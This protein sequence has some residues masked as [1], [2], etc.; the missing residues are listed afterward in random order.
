MVSPGAPGVCERRGCAAVTV[1]SDDCSSIR[2][3]AIFHTLRIG[4]VEMSDWLRRTLSCRG[5][6][7][8]HSTQ[9]RFG[10]SLQTYLADING[11]TSS[12]LEAAT[13]LYQKPES[14]MVRF[15]VRK[16]V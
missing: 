15:W 16:S 3:L 5:S 10:A 7:R 1:R 2:G 13:R 6:F 4:A 12:R 14:L 9:G 11:Y 8:Q